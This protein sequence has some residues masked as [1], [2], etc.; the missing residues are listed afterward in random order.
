MKIVIEANSVDELKQRV[1]EVYEMI[2]GTGEREIEDSEVEPGVSD[3]GTTD[4]P[5]PVKEKKTRKPRTTK[6]V[7]EET[8][9]ETQ[10]EPQAEEVMEEVE[11]PYKETPK[12]EKKETKTYTKQDVADA[13]QSVST[14]KNLDAARAVLAQ[15]TDAE[16]EPCRRISDLKTEEYGAFVAACEKA[17]L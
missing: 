17:K 14:A 15:F 13:C 5:A 16:G 10:T 6:P 1:S 11:S 9:A 4:E 3:S 12:E 8:Q 2:C 7:A